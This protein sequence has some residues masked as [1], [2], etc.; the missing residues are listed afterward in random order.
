MSLLFKKHWTTGPLVLRLTLAFIK[1]QK[2]N[3]THRTPRHPLVKMKRVRGDSPI[4]LCRGVSAGGVA[5]LGVP[6]ASR[7]KYG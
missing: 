6:L 1:Q 3:S 5:T 2:K 7:V 4:W